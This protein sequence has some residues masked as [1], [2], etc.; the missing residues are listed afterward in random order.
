MNLFVDMDGVLADFVQH[1]QAVF[2]WK[3]EKEDN[4]DWTAVREVEDFYLNIPPMTDLELLWV[5][6]ERYQPIVLTGV[7]KEIA[8]APANN[9][10]SAILDLMGV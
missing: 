3:P 5:R 8:E 9:G 10:T 7:A 4:V 2:G 1:H 6:I